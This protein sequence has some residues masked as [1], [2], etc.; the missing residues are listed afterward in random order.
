MPVKS[1]IHTDTQ[2]QPLQ[3]SIAQTSISKFNTH[4]ELKYIIILEEIAQDVG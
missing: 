3:D 2:Q 1:L 4:N